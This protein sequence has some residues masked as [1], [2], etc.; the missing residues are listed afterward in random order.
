LNTRQSNRAIRLFASKESQTTLSETIEESFVG[1]T[2]NKKEGGRDLSVLRKY[3]ATAIA[4]Q[5]LCFQGWQRI[6]QSDWFAAEGW[7]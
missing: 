6:V 1:I 2:F 5:R 4:Y 7:N 3:A